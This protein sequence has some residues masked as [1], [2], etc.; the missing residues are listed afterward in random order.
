MK[1]GF[2]ALVGKGLFI[3]AIALAGLWAGRSDRMEQTT[4]EGAALAYATWSV[5][6][7]VAVG[8]YCL[9]ARRKRGQEPRD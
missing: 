5:L 4:I 1:D 8:L 9:L 2:L 3:G 6:T 7:V